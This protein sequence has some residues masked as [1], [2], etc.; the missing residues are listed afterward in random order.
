MSI[1]EVFQLRT[2]TFFCPALT[3]TDAAVV[4]PSREALRE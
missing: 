1:S 3:R 2:T 4:R